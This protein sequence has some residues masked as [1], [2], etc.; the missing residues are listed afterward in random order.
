MSAMTAIASIAAASLFLSNPAPLEM[1]RASAFL[2]S[3]GGA[4]RLEDRFCRI[5]LWTSRAVDGRWTD[6]DGRVFTLS[7]LAV[8][9]PAVDAEATET[10][11]RYGEGCVP[12]DRRNAAHVREAVEA[13]SPV[14]VAEKSRP[15]RQ[16]P[17]GYDDVRYWQGTNES[18]VVCAFR[19]EKS[20]TW[21]LATWTMADGDD[22]GERVGVFEDEFLRKEFPALKSG[23]L[24]GFAPA[25]EGASEGELLRADARHSVAAYEAWRATD[26]G[27][28]A[29]LDDLPRSAGFL[30]ALTNEL[31]RLHRAYVEAMPT[32]ME[33]TNAVCVMR[34]YAGRDEYLAAMEA[35][36]R[37]GLEWSAAYWSPARR[38]LVAYLSEG[39]EGELMRTI[40]HEAFHQYLSYATAMLPTSPWLNE[41]YAQH[42]EDVER[43]SWCVGMDVTP[44]LLERLAGMLPA[45]FAL[46]YEGFYAG[47]DEDRRLKYR[48]AWSVAA[49]LE[50]GA[51]KVRFEPFKDVKRNYVE[52]LFSTRDPLKAT[53]AAFGGE[54][55]LRRFAAEWLRWWKKTAA[56]SDQ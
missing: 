11:T 6:D 49:F 12:V 39:G 14:A 28:Y 45:L 1:P 22:F 50:R 34:V 18:A 33:G 25:P 20:V 7:T 44:E 4:T 40:R 56:A 54:A 5:D 10:R 27:V 43:V 29:V 47:T 3:E 2:V 32:P 53:D 31:P 51:P 21:R 9:P 8:R 52:T 42:F 17:R 48:L 30:S 46:D 16:M 38:E 41:G 24:A 36:G 23:R 55:G 13:L 19:P 26:V 15:P 37:E 35:D